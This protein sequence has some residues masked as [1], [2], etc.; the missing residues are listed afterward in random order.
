[1]AAAARTQ[2]SRRVLVC[3][4]CLDETY[5]SKGTSIGLC[6]RTSFRAK[7]QQVSTVVEEVIAT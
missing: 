3:S 6:S 4:F 2:P 5:C 1:M 7:V